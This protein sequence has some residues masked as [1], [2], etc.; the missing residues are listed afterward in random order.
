[1]NALLTATAVLAVLLSACSDATLPPKRPALPHSASTPSPVSSSQ[2]PPIHEQGSREHRGPSFMST[3][4]VFFAITPQ[5]AAR[6]QATRDDDSLMS[7]L[8]EIE[9]AWDA[10][11]LAECDKAWDAMHRLLT[12]GN[13]AFGNGPEPLRHCVLGPAQLHRGENYIASLVAP[14]KVK[15]ISAA[16][17]GITKPAF[18]DRYRSIVPPTYAPEYGDEDRDY[19]WSWFQAVRDLYRKAAERNRFVLFTVGQ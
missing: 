12:D 8:D 9:E 1:M 18:D 17:S 3:R 10:D 14:A 13:L 2:Q 5:Q 15:D 11:N 6:L 19:T 4:G 16:L 7:L